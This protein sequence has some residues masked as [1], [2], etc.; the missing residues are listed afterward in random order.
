[1]KRIIYARE[2]PITMKSTSLN[3]S[4]GWSA[5]TM[6]ESQK[7]LPNNPMKVNRVKIT[8]DPSDIPLN[9]PKKRPPV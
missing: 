1:M 3:E 5:F 2:I 7:S 6:V 4:W 8:K 9:G